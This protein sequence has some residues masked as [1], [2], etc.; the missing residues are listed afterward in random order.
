MSNVDGLSSADYLG[1]EEWSSF[2]TKD[3]VMVGVLDGMFYDGRGEVTQHWRDLQVN[4]RS[5]HSDV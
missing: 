1:L 4:A 5:G 2:Y 3:Y